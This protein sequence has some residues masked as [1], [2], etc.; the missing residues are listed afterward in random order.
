MQHGP[1][2]R[3]GADGFSGGHQQGLRRHHPCIRGADAAN[4]TLNTTASTTADIIARALTVAA[5]GIHSVP[6]RRSS[7]LVTLSDNRVAGDH[8]TDASTTASFADKNV[9]TAKTV[10]VTGMSIS[11][12][13]AANYAFNTTA[14]TTA[15]ITARALT[16]SAA[17][18]NKVYD[19]TTDA[20]VTLSDDRV[21]GDVLTDAS[22]AASFADKNVGA[23]KTLSV[24][25][26][27]ISGADAA[28]YTFNPTAR[29]T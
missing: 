17:G 4:Y 10:S 28:N 23:A 26:I 6:A 20:T 29:N 5:A 12:P 25:G 14:S 22:T 15:D 1:H 8:L 27:S 21:A 19:G 9:A 16:V 11:G 2:H 7:D 13:D 24:T 3:S 18:M